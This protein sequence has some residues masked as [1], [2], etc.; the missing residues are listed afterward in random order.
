MLNLSI[1]DR[2]D[3]IRPTLESNGQTHL[4][5]QLEKLPLPLKAQL[6][7]DLESIDWTEFATLQQGAAH[8]HDWSKL[9]AKAEPPDAIR[10]GQSD[11]LDDQAR[12]IGEEAIRAGKVAM[13][14]VAGGQGTRL[15]F[16]KPKGMYSIGP[17]SGRTLFQMHVDSLLGAMKKFG[18]QIPLLVMTSPATDAE[19]RA[20]F[21]AN[22]NLGIP[23]GLLTIFVQGQ[24]PA[25]D[26]QSGE[27]L[28]ESP[29][30][31]AM[32][33][34]GHGGI[35]KALKKQGIL[36]SCAKNGIEHFYYAQID[37]PM[38]IAC[39]PTLVGHHI[40]QKSRMTTQVVQK[41][42]ATEKV[43]NVVSIDGRTQIIEY[44]DLPTSAA[45][46]TNTDGTLKL[47]AGNIAVH[48]FELAFLKE[49]CETPNAL[50]FHL[51]SKVVP[52]VNESG[53]VVKPS[54]PNATKFEQFVFDLLPHAERA[55]VVEGRAED[56]FAPVKN[57]D[58]AP[59]DTPHATKLALSNRAKRWMSAVG[60]EVAPDCWLEVNPLWAWDPSDVKERLQSGEIAQAITQDTYLA[61]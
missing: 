43:G 13:I 54:S 50:P 36:E 4:V 34:D 2:F 49:C 26:S 56:V 5:R 35:V 32:S 19:T 7:T 18:V 24:M 27:I 58:G 1:S 61:G 41:R 52:F 30:T 33:P 12:V 9:A 57:A 6:L 17:V 16:D 28:L 44:S 31:I 37:N 55:I 59:T 23:D 14:L 38:V 48:V 10:L 51:A 11:S 21:E 22:Q 53:D 8:S 3:Q 42:F 25:V 20:Y 60:V 39:D 29:S 45:E 46:Q 40:Q 47:W 15:G